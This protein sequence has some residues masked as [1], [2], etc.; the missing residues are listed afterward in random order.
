MRRLSMLRLLRS[1][2]RMFAKVGERTKVFWM[3][4]GLNPR[5]R[6]PAGL[7]SAPLDHSGIHP[8]VGCAQK[9]WVYITFEWCVG[10]KALRL[11]TKWSFCSPSLR[12]ARAEIVI[13]SRDKIRSFQRPNTGYE[14]IEHAEVASQSP[15]NVLK[16]WWAGKS[17]LNAVGFEP[18]RS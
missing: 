4:W 2:R 14:K 12:L 5:G 3:Q 7:K 6:K 15:E 13:Y 10:Y 8:I 11:P 16:S 1:R 18:T 9:L 17:I